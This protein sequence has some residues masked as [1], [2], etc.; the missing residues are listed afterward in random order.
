MALARR[1]TRSRPIRLLLTGVFALPLISLA[2]LWGFAAHVT[3]TSATRDHNYDSANRAISPAIQPVL[4]NLAAERDQA[5]GWLLTGNRPPSAALEATRSRTDQAVARARNGYESVRNLLSAQG[6]A[7]LSGLYAAL[8]QLGGIRTAIDSGAMSPIAAFEAYSGIADY[9]L[10]YM[11]GAPQAEVGP[12]YQVTIG[13]MDSDYALEMA[14]REA[15]LAGAALAARRP[16]SDSVRE[17]FASTAASRRLLVGDSLALLNPDLRAA[18]AGALTEDQRLTALENQ[19]SASPADNRAPLPVDPAAW[20]SAISGYLAAMQK[21]Q[22]KNIAQLSAM[23]VQVSNRLVTEAA[24]AAGVGLAALIIS[25]AALLWL[26]R[27]ITGELTGLL[28]SVRSMAE[29]RLP[30]VVAKLRR[31]DDVDVTAESPPP[32]TGV[33]REISRVAEAFSIVQGAAVEAAVDQAKLRKGISQIF[34]N[35][36][37]RNQSLLHRQLG[38]LDAMERRTSDPEALSDLFRLDHLTTR[39]RR[40]AEGLIIL[41]GITPGRGWRDPVPVV[42]VMR[43]AAAEVEDY[44]R[45]EVVSESRDSV[46]GTAVSDVIHLVAELV[47]NATAFS[48]PETRIE[49]RTER[50]ANGLVAEIED[51]GLGLG[52]QELADINQ[53]LAN[54]PEFDLAASDQL[55]LFIVG[56]LAARHGIQVTLRR[57]PYGG[58]TAI[59]LLPHGVV[60]REGDEPAPA[61]MT[62]HAGGDDR[63]AL[64][65]AAIGTPPRRSLP[66]DRPDDEGRTP[67][68]GLT[69]RHRMTALPAAHSPQ[70]PLPASPGEPERPGGVPRPALAPWETTEQEPDPASAERHL[71]MPV[72]VPQASLAPQLRTEAQRDHDRAGAE[73]GEPA[74]RSPEATRAMLLSMQDGWQRGRLDDLDNPDDASTRQS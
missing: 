47:E 56:R 10:H 37:M 43:A 20:Q 52:N 39:M 18:Y 55:G 67:A 73:A 40:H 14:G 16:M 71:G 15:A 33:I 59:V 5:Y 17:L 34:L 41:A 60:V 51:R 21:A 13:A 31:G 2:V 50:V 64:P 9:V 22:Y 1:Q 49:V 36:S 6:Q 27:R 48:P 25:T 19:I 65:G 28:G 62:G 46:A 57:S 68:F 69:G 44:V 29:E 8:G 12:I 3:L 38:M 74:G 30:R 24:L 53:Q 72:R 63:A 66:A 35:L 70:P 58:I 7:G 42:D 23:S 54:P 61:A 11:K 4:F 32:R 45:V 26:G